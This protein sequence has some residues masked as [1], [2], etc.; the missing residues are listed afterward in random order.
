M[1]REQL[2]GLCGPG[3]GVWRSNRF[4]ESPLNNPSV[5][6]PEPLESH[7]GVDAAAIFTFFMTG[8]GLNL[9]ESAVYY[10]SARNPT[11][12][13]TSLI[14]VA[15]LFPFVFVPMGLWLKITSLMLFWWAY[16]ELKHKYL[17]FAVSCC[18][19]FTYRLIK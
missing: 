9:P 14:F 4:L 16:V 7:L 17:R 8:L 1:K 11:C 18:Y 13:L 5:F 3:M 12:F 6:S 10:L 19:W 2:T 15:T